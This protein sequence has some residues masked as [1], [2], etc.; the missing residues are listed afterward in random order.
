MA[1]DVNKVYILSIFTAD[2]SFVISAARLNEC[3]VT[4]CCFVINI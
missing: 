3:Y 4:E 1:L 2:S